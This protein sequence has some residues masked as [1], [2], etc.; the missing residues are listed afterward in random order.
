ME[1][2]R[3]PG[4]DE[5]RID[6]HADGTIHTESSSTAQL[7]DIADHVRWAKEM[8]RLSAA[9]ERSGWATWVD[10]LSSAVSGRYMATMNPEIPPIHH[11]FEI[12]QPSDRFESPSLP[13]R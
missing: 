10:G 2:D 7:A 5:T 6:Q 8:H 3:A 9:L 12:L 13:P 1:H 11:R 4:R